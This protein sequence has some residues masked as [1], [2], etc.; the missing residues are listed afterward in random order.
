VTRLKQL[1]RFIKFLWN[2][3]DQLVVLFEALP[4]GL[5]L[6]GSGM[7]AAGEGAVLASRILGG[8]AAQAMNA[9]DAIQRASN[10]VEQCSQHVKSVAQEIRDV[11]NALEQIKVPSV[12]AEKRHFD[13]RA[14]GL[15]EHDLVTGLTYSDAYLFGTVTSTMRNQANL[16]DIRIGGQ[17]HDASGHL[18]NLGQK[19]DSAGN[20][21]HSVG[22]S[23]KEGGA[24]LSQLGS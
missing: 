10:T 18:D 4:A 6:A 19:L 8:D 24:A 21:L 2:H 9:A 12:T 20:R 14:I 15:G 3:S 23:L 22:D 5:R 7:Q 16:V 17:L 13:F 1:F 11:A